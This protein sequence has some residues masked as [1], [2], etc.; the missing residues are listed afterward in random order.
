MQLNKHQIY[1]DIY[2]LMQTIEELP[3]SELQSK[4]VTMAGKLQEPADKLVD[5]LLRIERD[6]DELN[7]LECDGR[8]ESGCGKCIRCIAAQALH[9]PNNQA[10]LRVGG[11]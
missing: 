9:V 4:I 11:K 3:A 8:G 10:H 2:D 7:G 1:R 5:A 6:F